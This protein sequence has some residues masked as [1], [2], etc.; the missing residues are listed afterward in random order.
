MKSFPAL[1]LIGALSSSAPGVAAPLS[2]YGKLPFIES[3]ALS[4][5]G[6]MLAFA[7]TDGEKRKI[8]VEDIDGQKVTAGLN[9]GEH[10]IRDIQWAGSN[11]LIITETVTGYIPFIVSPRAEWAIGIDFNIAKRSQRAL[12]GNVDETLNVIHGSPDI[13]FIDGHPFAFVTG[14]LFVNNQGQNAL[15]SVDLD[16]NDHAKVENQGFEHTVDY[17]VDAKGKPLAES[18]YDAQ[19]SRWV[20]RLWK[21]QWHEVNRETAPIERPSLLGLGRDG[22]SVAVSFTDEKRSVLRELSPQT[23]AW[24]DPSPAPDRLIWDPGTYRMIGQVSLVGDDAVYQFFDP[25]DQNVWKAVTAAYPGDR[26]SLGSASIDHRRLVVRVDSPASGPAYALVDLNTKHGEWIGDEYQDLKPEDIGPKQAVAFKAR[27]GLALTG[28]LTLPRGK[29][30][31]GLPL[32]VFPHGGP[33]ARDEPGFDWWAQ[34]MASRGYA[35]L[36][37]NYRGS[38]GF[39]WEFMSAGFGQWGRKMQTDLSDGVGYL[40]AQG[41]ID[42]ARVC[43]VGASYGGYAAL[44]GATLDAGVYRCAASVAGPSDLRKFV[45]DWKQREGDQG[46][47]SQRYWLRYMGAATALDEISPARQAAKVKIPILLV[48]GKDDTVVP[49]VQSQI[50]AD[51][52]HDAGKPVEFV[53]LKK[54]DHWLSQGDTRLQMLESVMAFLEKNNPAN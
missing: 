18:E 14:T 33:A 31:K 52:L 53:T 29:S 7:V 35:V 44:A 36:Q 1:A 25:A 46:V 50:M 26:V 49:F 16:R 12:V 19:K 3:T 20:L 42:P 39:G 10:K 51:A 27:D 48:H 22:V 38:D 13:R 43:I 37:V 30:A 45:A 32:V 24:T 6:R 54:E 41:T 40:A 8:L 9:A 21:D 47:G 23:G 28:Y 2:A 5:D 17:V 11:H 15:F 4:P 34:A